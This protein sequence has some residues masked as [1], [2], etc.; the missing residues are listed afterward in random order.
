M[1]GMDKRA[2]RRSASSVAHRPAQLKPGR[3]LVAG[4]KMVRWRNA[5]LPSLPYCCRDGMLRFTPWLMG[6]RAASHTRR[7]FISHHPSAA[8]A[9]RWVQRAAHG[10]RYTP[11]NRPACSARSQSIQQLHQCRLQHVHTARRGCLQPQCELHQALLWLH[12][13]GFHRCMTMVA[14]KAGRAGSY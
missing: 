7:A 13:K 8:H 9:A 12:L 5:R 4:C 10:G 1:R 2:G 6:A 11:P 14:G 3:Q